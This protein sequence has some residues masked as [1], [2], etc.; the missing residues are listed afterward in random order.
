MI[1]RN[2]W[3][4][5]VSVFLSRNLNVTPPVDSKVFSRVA[6]EVVAAIDLQRQPSFLA[7]AAAYCF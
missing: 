1:V 6:A 3:A 2:A 7:H 4:S 5:C